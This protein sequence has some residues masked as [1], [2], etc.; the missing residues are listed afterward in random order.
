MPFVANG[1]TA[2]I[3]LPHKTPIHFPVTGNTRSRS[4]LAKRSAALEVIKLLH[5][6]GELTEDLKVKN[7]E[8]VDL[9]D[10]DNDED[11]LIDEEGRSGARKYYKVYPPL[12]MTDKSNDKVFLH[13][14][15]LKLVK[16]IQN[17]R[18]KLHFPETDSHSLGLL[19]SSPLP[20]IG[21]LEIFGPSGLVHVHLRVKWK[22]ITMSKELQHLAQRFHDYI[23]SHCLQQ[24]SLL[25]QET[26][27][28]PL[29]VPVFSKNSHK[30]EDSRGIDWSMC[31]NIIRYKNTNLVY[32]LA[33]LSKT[34]SY[35]QCFQDLV[36][37]P[38][39]LET[40]GPGHY[41]IEEVSPD[42]SVSTVMEGL[43]MSMKEYHK[44]HH[45]TKI[46]NHH[47]HL[48]RIS[49]A[50]KDLYMFSPGGE[51]VADGKKRTYRSYKVGELMAVEPIPAGLWK[52]AQMLPWI[53]RR[54]YSLISALQF[55]NISWTEK[56]LS[57]DGIHSVKDD[58]QLRSKMEMEEMM[59]FLIRNSRFRDTDSSPSPGQI[60]QAL[61]L[62]SAGDNWD[63]E[64]LEILGDA[65]L[66]YSTT[67]FL[68]YK[69][70][71]TCDEGDLTAARS[72][73]VG[74]KNLMKI[75]KTLGLANCDIV[76]HPM[77]PVKT[78]IPPGYSSSSLDDFDTIEDR[79]VSL[80]NQME[81]WQVGQLAK[82]LKK[83]DLENLRNGN[84]TDEE[85]IA[86]VKERK[87]KHEQT[88][89]VPLRSYRILSD[90]SQA[91]CIEAMM[92]CY[93]YNCG[94]EMCLDFMAS[95]GINLDSGAD[96][97]DV[98]KRVRDKNNNHYTH[99]KPQKD[100]FVNEAARLEIV[101]FNKLIN[102]LGV[103]E[104]ENTVGYTFKEKS[105]LL[106][107]FTHPSYED[108]RLT[109]SYEKLEFLGDAVLDYLVS[110]YIFT[111]T[112]ADPGRLT[113]IRSALVCNNMF[114]S[115]L[116]D[117]NLDKFIL[118]CNPGILNKIN[119]YLDIRYENRSKSFD[120]T[121]KQF[122]ED[123]VPEM[124]LIEVPKVLGDVLEAIIGA[125]YIDSG[126]DLETVWN[127]YLRLCPNLEAVVKDPPQNMKKEL[128]EKYPS[129][130]KFS[131]ARVEA[132]MVFIEAEVDVGASHKK[133]FRGRGKNKTL[134]TLAACKCALRELSRK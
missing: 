55:V 2:T 4:D 74:N 49:S 22:P 87:K 114:A 70:T 12:M 128:L 21:P 104:I 131:K 94:M 92:G 111:H 121:M 31:E 32:N 66:K 84:V 91:D 85:L 8:K 103:E 68:Y 133:I 57:F 56:Q 123:D 28:L 117:S 127:V 134:A 98:F 99:F 7:R 125:I 15:E 1:F 72:R 71:D 80:D 78:W 132:D 14:I 23:F 9:L 115:L 33:Q 67:I 54:V 82:L 35:F 90:K 101:R 77:D 61:T 43:G 19:T 86:L 29:I 79:I 50:S 95:I 102:K 120:S 63:M 119:A 18:Y 47:Q 65:F 105:F 109:H 24:T 52:Q 76:S 39:V 42:L 59:F 64:R 41:F 108:N 73:I 11:D 124:E 69:M 130:V 38:L 110:C 10:E 45:Q 106:E 75:A 17:P 116:T 36:L 122:N 58:V 118:H 26:S 34:F 62:A 97:S 44:V 96:I 46:K 60:V 3:Q 93:L 16:P 37:Y 81:S 89:G 5:Q 13:I 30:H 83:E 48:I 88:G 6:L 27:S 129:G 51:P 126:H 53:L 20:L 100:A 113:D 107:A 40:T 25:E 112:S